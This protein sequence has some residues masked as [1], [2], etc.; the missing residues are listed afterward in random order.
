MCLV[1]YT[2][3]VAGAQYVSHPY[4]AMFKI[5]YAL[6]VVHIWLFIYRCHNEAV[7]SIDCDGA[8]QGSGGVA[9]FIGGSRWWQEEK[10]R[11]KGATSDGKAD[12][13]S[14]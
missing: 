10:R 7:P 14:G 2:F 3:Y 12:G 1:M 5:L 8:G 11:R 6:T 4:C 9:C 13:E